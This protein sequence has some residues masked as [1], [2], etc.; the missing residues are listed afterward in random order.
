MPYPAKYKKEFPD[1]LVEHMQGGLSFESFGGEP[2]VMC[3]RRT[4]YEWLDKY[5]E[6][7]KAKEIGEMSGLGYWEKTGRLAVL[8]KIKGFQ[9]AVY[10][11][12]MKARFAKYGWRD[13]P[14]D[15]DKLNS[16]DRTDLANK[17]LGQ[18]STVL[19]DTSCPD[20][21]SPFPSSLPPSSSGLLG[22]TSKEK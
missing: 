22:D 8:G 3:N 5:P 11:F 18:L 1:M 6:F 12:T 16:K 15:P 10:I 21:S 20:S 14:E 7:L 4:L 9:A 19:K 13:I 2:K 17:L